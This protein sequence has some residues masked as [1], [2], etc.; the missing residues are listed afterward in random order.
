MASVTEGK[1]RRKKF[2]REKIDL[3]RWP[4]T[5]GRIRLF[6]G[7]LIQWRRL[8]RSKRS[9]IVR[10]ENTVG[11]GDGLRQYFPTLPQCTYGGFVMRGLVTGATGFIGRQLV[12][13]LENPVVLSRN[14][15]RAIERLGQV[16]V[17]PW[18][19]TSEEPPAEAFRN[20]EAVFHLAGE[21][22]GEGRWTAAKKRRIRASRVDGTRHLVDALG[23]LSSRPGVLV[24]A[25]AVGYYGSRGD[26]VLDESSPPGEDF[27]A[28]TCKQW[29]SESARAR[30]HGLRVVNPRTGIVLGAGGGALARMLLPFK[31]CIG[32]RLGTGRQWMPW[33]HIEDL[34]GLL[35]AAAKDDRF[36]GPINAVAPTQVTNREF[37]R[38]LASVLRRPAVFP[39]PRVALRMALGEFGN[40]LLTSQR[41]VPTAAQTAGYQFRYDDLKQALTQIIHGAKRETTPAAG[42]AT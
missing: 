38:V 23:R 36:D 26:E 24:S 11:T 20:V 34:V 30:D 9:R 27:L 35:L 1:S 4:R 42:E 13:R 6:A 15:R 10:R 37:T 25:S 16:Q 39:A 22:V 7:S 3:S 19:P 29:E 21:S 5:A 33:I 41:A 32:G 12:A 40:V 8:D 28:E 31:L 17:F 14:P 18:D 2:P